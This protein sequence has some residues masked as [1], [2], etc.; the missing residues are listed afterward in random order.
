MNGVLSIYVAVLRDLKHTTGGAQSYG[1][2]H[3]SERSSTIL[4][5]QIAPTA[6]PDDLETRLRNAGPWFHNIDVHGV[7][8][9]PEHFLGDY[10]SVK[11]RHLSTAL[12]ANLSGKSVL[13]IG[14]NAGFYSV[15]MKRRGAARVL[16]IDTEEH[17]LKQARLVRD[18]LGLDIEYRRCSAYD[19]PSLAET[20]D[21]VL[22]MG[23]FYHLRYPLYALDRVVQTVAAGGLLVFQT[24][25][26][27]HA[28]A[29]AEKPVAPDYPFWETDAFLDPAFPHMRF[30]EHRFAGD[31]TNWWIPNLQ[32]M[33]AMLRSAGLR[34]DA[35]PEQETW[36]CSPVST[37]RDGLSL[38]ELEF[39][40]RLW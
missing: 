37:Q 36:L 39:A 5:G 6:P 4:A 1:Y 30:F 17:Y 3:R 2:T 21:V 18:E 31:A 9:A 7:Q 8:T 35:R 23:L 40:G 12:P 28:V 24:L 16:G 22:F 29:S 20:F 11:W 15:E 10:P 33:E 19:V 25:F 26:R 14:C 13:D 34:I 38:Q 27:P 32:G